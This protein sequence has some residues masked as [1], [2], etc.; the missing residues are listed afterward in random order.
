MQNYQ[1]ITTEEN[2]SI[3]YSEELFVN[4]DLVTT[5][6]EPKIEETQMDFKLDEK[7]KR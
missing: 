4:N 1:E 3:E 2:P 6:N 7:M 5:F